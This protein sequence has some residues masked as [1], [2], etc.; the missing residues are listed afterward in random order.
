MK[1]AIRRVRSRSTQLRRRGRGP[2]AVRT[3]GHR[4][5]SPGAATSHH[6]AVVDQPRSGV[7][8]THRQ[9]ALLL[10]CAE[11]HR[12]FVEAEPPASTPRVLRRAIEDLG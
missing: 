2:A 10:E 6:G 5:R 7:V 11:Q 1:S 9:E 8:R 3:V 12:L 4:A